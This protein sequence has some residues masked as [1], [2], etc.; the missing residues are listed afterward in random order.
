MFNT[1]KA[2]TAK[3]SMAKASMAK[4]S[5]AKASTAL[6]L[7]LAIIALPSCAEASENNASPNKAEIESVIKAYL[8]ENPEIIRDALIL[9]EEK[10]NRQS[11]RDVAKEL[12]HD[13]RDYSIGPKNAKVTIVEFFDYNCTFC[14]RSTAWV[15]SVMAT[16]PKDVRV[17]FKELP[18]LDRR[19]RTS[20]NAAKAALAAH[21]Q[22]KY[23]EMHFALMDASD[24]SETFINTT[25]KRLGLNM[26]KFEAALKD[27]ALDVQL[28]DGMRLAGR[29]PGLTGT[30]FFVINDTFLASGDTIALQIMLDME[31]E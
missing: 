17:I 31:L 24:L 14:K 3:A 9:L 4:A 28:E 6:Y 20:R 18:I 21:K 8:L 19:T 26:R 22:G 23:S 10:E 12:R 7:A 16:Y 30:P 1:F 2:S 15:Q 11:I 5:M 27:P 29:I 25:A 13:S